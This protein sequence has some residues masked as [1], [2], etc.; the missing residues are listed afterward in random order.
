MNYGPTLFLGIFLAFA[1]AWL[2]LVFFP[3]QQLGHLKPVT[4]EGETVANPRPYSG[5]ELRGRQVYQANGCVYCHS[6][7]V[8]GG[9]YNADLQRGWGPRRTVPQDYVN[10]DPVLLG[11]MR[12]G[13][14]LVNVGARLTDDQWHYRHLY[15][16][17]LTSPGSI[18]PPHRFLFEKRKIAGQ[19]SLDAVDIPGVEAG[20]EIVP[21]DD[22]KALVAYLKSLDRTYDLK[23]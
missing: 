7:Q 8:R 2:G 1:S 9:E 4:A 16:P 19:K 18:M 10:D 11:T 21:S 23:K 12:T 5:L 13:P 14:D 17:V 15:D 20:Y 22:A 6:Q 3:S